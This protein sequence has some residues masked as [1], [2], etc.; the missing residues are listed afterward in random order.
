MTA[1]CGA[2]TVSCAAARRGRSLSRG[3]QA[4]TVPSQIR[5]EGSLSERDNAEQ[6]TEFRQLCSPSQDRQYGTSLSLRITPRAN[7]R[8]AIGCRAE[9]IRGIGSR[10]TGRLPARRKVVPVHHSSYFFI[11][12][13]RTRGLL[14]YFAYPYLLRGLAATRTFLAASESLGCQSRE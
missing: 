13:N 6:R 5:G 4:V 8:C 3:C 14:G 2:M 10:C 12:S 9:T 7:R 1:T 11:F